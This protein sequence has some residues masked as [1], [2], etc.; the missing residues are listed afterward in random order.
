M[1][2]DDEEHRDCSEPIDIRAVA[3]LLAHSVMPKISR[4][5]K[6]SPHREQ[7]QQAP[8]SLS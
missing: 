3:Q 8:F 7:A 4:L 2:S 5:V 6:N 1:E